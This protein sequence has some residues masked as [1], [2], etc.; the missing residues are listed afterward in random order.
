[1]PSPP[2][3]RPSGR[4]GRL[5]AALR[6]S[7]AGPLPVQTGFPTS[8]ADLVVKNHGRLKKQPSPSSKRWRR[9]AS[10]SPSPSVSPSPAPSPPPASPPPPPPPAAV[11][12]SDQ[13][14]PDLQPAR[15]ARGGKGGGFGLGLGFLAFSGVVSLAL[16]VIWSR[17]V[18]AAVTVASFSLFLLESVRSSLRPGRPRRPAAMDGRLLLDSRGRV[19]P[20]REVDAETAPSRPS[21]SDTDRGSEVSILAVE[22]DSGGLDEPTSPKAKAKTKKRSWKKLIASA[23][24]LHKGRKGKEADSL[25][26]FRSDGDGDDAAASSVRRGNATAT[27]SRRG[28]VNQT[29]AGAVA[30]E[31]DSPRGSR[32]SQGAVEIVAAAPVEIDAPVDLVQEEEEEGQAAGRFPAAPVLVA[33]ALAGL[34]AGKLPAVALTVLCY[35]FLNSAQGSPRGGGCP[36]GRRSEVPR[37]V[38]AV[39]N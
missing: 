1:M 14:R 38:V 11:S 7:R 12:P 22:Q 26:S 32:R 19:S 23:K 10:P 24:K 9:G 29:D 28:T 3:E 15:P 33:V 4:L 18:V 8:L 36:P 20:I 6:P 39:V 21:C 5:L 2:K 25:G 13:P 34:V 16:L 37:V 31:P 30:G 35:A 27:D 17:K